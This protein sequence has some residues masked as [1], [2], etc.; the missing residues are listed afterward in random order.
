MAKQESSEQ[1]RRQVPEDGANA[2]RYQL[3]D[4]SV[5]SPTALDPLER[6]SWNELRNEIYGGR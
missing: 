4:R 1:G 2:A 3:S 6:M 5:G